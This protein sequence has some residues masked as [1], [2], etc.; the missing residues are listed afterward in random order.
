MYVDIHW[1]WETVIK[2]TTS[3]NGEKSICLCSIIS[4]LAYSVTNARIEDHSFKWKST[5]ETH[6]PADNSEPMLSCFWPTSAQPWHWTLF[7]PLKDLPIRNYY[8][9]NIQNN[10][11]LINWQVK[12]VEL[13]QCDKD[14]RRW[15]KKR[16]VFINE[17]LDNEMP[18]GSDRNKVEVSR[19]YSVYLLNIIN[20]PGGQRSN[21]GI[22]FEYN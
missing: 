8:L 4:N 5:F 1:W 9:E 14:G 20:I 13:T 19:A 6:P 16:N 2:D 18:G 3:E 22:R 15:H 21:H 17:W 10:T 7:Q 11:K 12:Y